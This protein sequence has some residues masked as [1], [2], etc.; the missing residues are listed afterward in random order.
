[1][2]I[3][4][5]WEDVQQVELMSMYLGAGDN[6]IIVATD[7]SH[8]N[9]VVKTNKGLSVVLL[10][11]RY[12]DLEESFELF[13]ETRVVRPEIPIVCG[14]NSEDIFRLARY[15]MAGMKSYILRDPNGDFMFLLNAMMDSVVAAT[16][17]ER[18]QKIAEKLREEVESV[19]KL[20]ETIIPKNIKPPS[21]YRVCAR[22]EPS[23]VKVLGG[24][25]VT[26]AGGDYYDLFGLKNN[27]FVVLVGDASGHGMKAC[28]SVIT[29]HTLV[30]MLKDDEHLMPAEFVATVNRNLC[31]QA[32]V[33]ADGGFI[34]L[35]YGILNGETHEF[36]WCSAGHPT[37]LIQ[38][39]ET[40]EIKLVATEDVG[41][42]PLG[43]FEGAEY[44][45]H[46]FT[47]PPKSRLLLYTDGLQEAFPDNVEKHVE[48][49][50]SGISETMRKNKAETIEKTMMSLFDDSN[51]F[52]LGNGRHDDTSVVFIERY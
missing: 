36:Q 49:G 25:S 20:Q 3:L 46:S 51:A 9:S 19:R 41:G 52:T 38:S 21:G 48:F 23:Q 40:G 39:L 42:M 34:T 26:M 17:A 12:P 15:M 33:S 6:E 47:I 1:M 24:Q 18:E 10:S 5:G 43:L 31:E 27:K 50:I 45:Q 11:T 16:N 14:C 35:A 30:R 32:I 44:V 2:I 22:Y 13:K 4:I 28:M 37:P 8:F 7:K 29:M